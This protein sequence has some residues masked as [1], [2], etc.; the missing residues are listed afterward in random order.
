MQLP[1]TQP[2]AT[3]I[4]TEVQSQDIHAFLQSIA[5]GYQIG[6]STF[7]QCIGGIC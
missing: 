4:D 2:L 6:L 3:H 7:A 1:E 5:E